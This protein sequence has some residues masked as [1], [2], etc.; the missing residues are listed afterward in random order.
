MSPIDEIEL[1]PIH[2]GLRPLSDDKLELELLTDEWKCRR[3][4]WFLSIHENR[5]IV[6]NTDYDDLKFILGADSGWSSED[7]WMDHKTTISAPKTTDSTYSAPKPT[8]SGHKT[9]SAPKTTTSAPKATMSSSKVTTSAPGGDTQ[10]GQ[11]DE[12]PPCR[13]PVP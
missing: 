11:F 9:M 7:E 5:N 10:M 1:L 6:A 13:K 2:P 4:I 3:L 8:A 12:E